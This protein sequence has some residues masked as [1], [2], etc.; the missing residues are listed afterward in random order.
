VPGDSVEEKG[1]GTIGGD[2]GG[3]GLATQLWARSSPT[4]SERS[5]DMDAAKLVEC[6]IDASTLR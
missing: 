4:T 3:S 1:E 6:Y 5:H 2:L